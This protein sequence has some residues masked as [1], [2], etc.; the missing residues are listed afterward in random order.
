MSQTE[1]STNNVITDFVLVKV[2]EREGVQEAIGLY[3]IKEDAYAEALTLYMQSIENEADKW[4]KSILAEK[5]AHIIELCRYI[6]EDLSSFE[7]RFDYFSKKAYLVFEGLNETYYDV[8]PVIKVNESKEHSLNESVFKTKVRNFLDV[9]QTKSDIEEDLGNSDDEEDDE[10]EE[11]EDLE[12]EDLEEE[13]EDLE[14]EE[15][16]LDENQVPETE[17]SDEE[18]ELD[19]ELDEEEEEE[20]ERQE[21]SLKRSNTEED[22]EM[23]KKMKLMKMETKTSY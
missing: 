8:L 17:G 6:K 14:E 19:E 5:Q 16:E 20:E 11:E 21:T 12:E 22:E 1:E 18:E 7:E 15:E 3:K 23:K 13:E 2:G 4:S 9:F 10:E